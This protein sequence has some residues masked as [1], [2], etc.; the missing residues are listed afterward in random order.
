MSKKDIIIIIAG[1]IILAGIVLV[2]YFLPEQEQGTISVSTDKGEY[3]LGE[4]LKVKIANNT[5]DKLCFSTCYPYYFE[6]KDEEWTGYK[7][8]ECPQEDMVDSCVEAE[9]VK[10]F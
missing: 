4:S 6:K 10:A 2:A 5:K 1:V 3:A 8:E 7:Y 9:E